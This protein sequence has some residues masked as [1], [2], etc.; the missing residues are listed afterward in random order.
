[1]IPTARPSFTTRSSISAAHVKL[2]G[3]QSDLAHHR[4]V[5]AEQKLLPGL[6]GGIERPR[7]L[8]PAKRAVVEQ[9]AVL[10][11]E[12]N[13]LGHGLVDDV[14]RELGKSIDVCLPGPVVPSL[15]GVIKEP[16]DRVA[17]V[18]IVLGG[19]DPALR[20][21]GVSPP[22]RVVIGEDLDVVAEFGQ[23]GRGGGAG[24]A[25]P[26]DDDLELALV[27][28]V[29]ELDREPMLVPLLGHRSGWNLAVEFG[30]LTF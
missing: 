10:P 17:I 23:A 14:Q 11:G 2:D 27:G 1:M 19:V 16:V 9:P 25:G 30:G 5:G 3:P 13:S 18:A 20:G 7:Y 22:G 8:C 26:D 21:D 4:L 15:D 6:T 29:D 24:E 12:G 28:G